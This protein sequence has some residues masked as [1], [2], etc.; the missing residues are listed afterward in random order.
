MIAVLGQAGYEVDVIFDS[1]M[2]QTWERKQTGDSHDLVQKILATNCDVVFTS[3]NAQ[4]FQWHNLV[5]TELKKQA[6]KIVT[7]F[8][9]PQCTYAHEYVVKQ[10]GVDYLC[11]GEGE[12]AI[13]EFLDYL[14]GMRKDLPSGIYHY[15]EG[16]V[17]GSNLGALVADLDSL[18]F[19]DKT[20]FYESHGP[21]TDTYVVMTGRGCYNTCTF[22]N[23]YTILRSYKENG[24]K[25]MRR[26]SVND[27]IR[28]LRFVKENI[29]PQS[30]AFYDDVFI[31]Q[32][33]WMEEFVDRYREEIDLPFS[34]ETIAN[35][36]REDIIDKLVAAGM[37]NV[38]VGIQSLDED[39]R[40]KVLGR[41]ESNEQFGRFV[42]ILKERGVS[43]HSDQ[44][45]NP[46]DT[47]ESLKPQIALF[48]EIRP[49]VINVFTLQYFPSTRI[50]DYAI[51]AGYLP[52]EAKAEFDKGSEDSFLR[53]KRDDSYK[54]LECAV[55]LLSLSIVLPRFVT[56]YLLKDDHI[57]LMRVVPGSAT[58]VIRAFSA[59]LRK[60]DI[61]GRGHILSMLYS[62]IGIGKKG[63]PGI[64]GKL[65]TLTWLKSQQIR[66]ED[67]ASKSIAMQGVLSRKL[68]P[69]ADDAKPSSPDAI[70]K[71]SIKDL[72]LKE[73]AGL[74]QLE[75][76]LSK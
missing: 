46:W 7:C 60:G 23:S 47:E 35:F 21:V 67:S 40:R 3:V 11:R 64:V 57:K 65:R 45:I 66:G 49:A 41:N 44:I 54:H 15:Q 62:F 9:G 36:F 26:R 19:P 56:R 51:S 55:A 43:V 27:V 16:K 13:L 37:K 10:D 58:L 73:S 24:Q 31:Y 17:V 33:R 52:A 4:N 71:F 38:E 28:E 18:P 63:D 20:D 50:I 69:L 48:S 14:Q 12:I 53:V 6:P 5:L 32:P 39:F 76:G 68:D 22:C 42:K 1:V 2:T 8:G 61:Y 34:C 74:V 75:G 25:F 70:R 59:L 30:I 72:R 29:K